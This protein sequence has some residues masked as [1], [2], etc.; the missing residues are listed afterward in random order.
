MG[1]TTP[2]GQ[3]VDCPPSDLPPTGV[4]SS[5]LRPDGL[6]GMLGFLGLFGA[7][8]AAA[9]LALRMSDRAKERA[10]A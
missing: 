3:V 4:G 6:N 2:G 10:D 9:G 1:E 7:G 5:L 8:A